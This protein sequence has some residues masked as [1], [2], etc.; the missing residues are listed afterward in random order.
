MLRAALLALLVA[1]VACEKDPPP[2]KPRAVKKKVDTDRIPVPNHSPQVMSDPG[3]P[4]RVGMEATMEAD[5]SGRRQHFT[6][7]PKGENAAV[8]FEDKGTAWVRIEG[9]LSEEGEPALTFK[10]DDL[11]LD[12]LKFP[13]TFTVGEAKKKAPTLAVEWEIGPAESW[14][15]AGTSERPM[16]L[17]LERFEGRTLHGTFDGVLPPRAPNTAAPIVIENGTFAVNLRLTNVKKGPAP[18]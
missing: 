1:S 17:T 8:Y 15:T 11:R 3:K 6:F 5:F 14:S 4:R 10:L 12:T 13:A 2:P 9:A 7:F 18:Q 16:T